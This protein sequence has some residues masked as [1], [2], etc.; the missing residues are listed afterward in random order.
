MFQLAYALS[1]MNPLKLGFGNLCFS[2][3]PLSF[4]H[5]SR[6]ASMSSYYISQIIMVN[7]L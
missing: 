4:V 2:I 6:L 1:T 5:T 3:I 7:T